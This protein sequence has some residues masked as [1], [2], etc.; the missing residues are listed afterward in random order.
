[1][2]VLTI[3]II[4]SIALMLYCMQQNRSI[5][6]ILI[7]AFVAR[8]FI[9]FA[10]LEHWFSIL[11]SGADTEM[12]DIMA[13]RDLLLVE[14]EFKSGYVHFLTFI[15]SISDGSRLLAQYINVLF[16]MGI[17]FIM[18]KTFRLLDVPMKQQKVGLSLVAFM[19]NMIIFSAIL[20]RE[21]WVEFFVAASVLQFVRWYL[22]GNS[23][24]MTFCI[25]MILA[26]CYMHAGVI[27]LLLGYIFGFLAY[28][29]KLRKVQFTPKAI[30]SI[31]ILGL[32]FIA[33][34]GSLEMFT[35]KFQN[36]DP[37]STEDFL[38]Y[39]N[40]TGVGGSGY[41]QWLPQTSNPVIGILVAPLRMFYFLFSPLPTEW[42][43]VSNIVGF[44]IDGVFYMWMCWI[45]YTRRALLHKIPLKNFLVTAILATAFIFG[46]GTS[47]AGTA[48]RHRAKILPAIVITYAISNVSTKKYKKNNPIYIDGK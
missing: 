29:P 19:P 42:H 41:L 9:L 20:L 6:A 22:R 48:F 39:A 43:R 2:I 28:N 46:Y 10:D 5:A 11:N 36:Y 40:K 44:L 30:V 25:L 15:Y 32:L 13:R 35:G 47:N 17:L 45:I 3:I 21:A 37:E 26:A 16:G 31:I 27:G 8:I 33:F 14:S 23:M 24:N 38:L 1:M 7:L 12:F 4:V 18:L 34:A